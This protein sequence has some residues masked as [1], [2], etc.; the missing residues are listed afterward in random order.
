M[1][2][3]LPELGS[4]PAGLVLDG[5]LVAWKSGQPH[6]PLVCRRVLNGDTTVPLTYVIFDVLRRDGDDLTGKPYR[7]RPATLEELKLDGGS[8]TSA[9]TFEDGPAL[10]DAV[11]RLGLEGVVAKRLAS[12]YRANQRGWSRRRIRTTGVATRSARR[13]SARGS[14]VSELTSSARRAVREQVA[15]AIGVVAPAWMQHSSDAY[16][17]NRP[18]PLI[19]EPESPLS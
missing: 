1:T 5:E 12:R 2:E 6:F 14:V 3:L 7:S 19:L 18:F 16:S 9:E 13:C 8:W 17:A 11:C 15:A 4:L 10:F